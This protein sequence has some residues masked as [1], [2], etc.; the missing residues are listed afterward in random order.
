MVD[1]EVVIDNFVVDELVD[2]V[3]VVG[4]EVTKH[5]QAEDTLDA[6]Y[7]DTYVGSGWFGGGRV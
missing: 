3:K 4:V 7:C 6:G 1:I 2:V 5:E